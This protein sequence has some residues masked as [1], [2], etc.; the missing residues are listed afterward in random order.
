MVLRGA[1]LRC[2]ERTGVLRALEASLPGFRP[3]SRQPAAALHGAEPAGSGVAGAAL[4]GARHTCSGLTGAALHS[5]GRTG[6][7]LAGGTLRGGRRAEVGRAAG[8]PLRSTRRPGVR[9]TGPCRRSVGVL[10]SRRASLPGTP[11]SG[12]LRRVGAA[13]HSTRRVGFRLSSTLLLET[14]V[15][16]TGTGA[17]CPRALL[18]RLRRLLWPLRLL[19]LGHVHNCAVP[20]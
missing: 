6:S 5:A 18:L 3:G 2:A 11:R 19:V 8:A 17:T 14:G 7:R 15:T 16:M 12:G 1:G 9:P 10:R 4:H 20:A 13:L